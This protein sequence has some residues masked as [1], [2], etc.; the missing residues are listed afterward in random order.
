M[1]R[2]NIKGIFSK[3]MDPKSDPV[4]ENSNLSFMPEVSQEQPGR[5]KNPPKGKGY[6][7]LPSEKKLK[8]NKT[9]IS[10]G[11][12]M[13]PFNKQADEKFTLQVPAQ[14]YNDQ[15]ERKKR[16]MKEPGYVI[17]QMRVQNGKISVI[18]SRKL[19]GPF[20]ENENIIQNG[21]VYEALLKDQRIA[22]GSIPD[23]GEQRSF[24]RPD[25]SQ[26]GHYITILPSFDFNVKVSTE[27]I[28]LKDLPNIKL[29]LYRFKEHVPDLSLTKMPLNVQY[30]KEIRT[31]AEMNG[32]R[33]E[34]LNE[35][36]KKSLRES[37][38]E[39]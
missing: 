24:A 2:K 4:I 6:M 8:I 18:N 20:I 14:G 36:V 31:V 13:A 27:K 39:K 32:I 12:Q 10:K 5:I 1:K 38:K 29:N 11:L 23:Y 34:Q 28:T 37:L 16:K 7:P 22:I 35:N 17:L 19:E 25:S 33:I 30:K 3:P 15:V 9:A 26:E 21:I